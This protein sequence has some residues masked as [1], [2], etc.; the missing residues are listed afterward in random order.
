M[1]RPNVRALALIAALSVSSAAMA[2]PLAAAQDP[3]PAAKTSQVN[4]NTASSAELEK[5]PGIGAATAT[6][7]IEYRQKN[8]PFKKTEE[9]MNVRGIGE[10][11]YLKLRP[12]VTVTPPKAEP[13]SR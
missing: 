1:T 4:I 2:S 3:A 7:I 5:L 6:R 12:L 13:A 9:L 8:G 11:S 10:K